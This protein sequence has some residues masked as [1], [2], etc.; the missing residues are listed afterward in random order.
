MISATCKL[1]WDLTT[2][3]L[4]V[5]K[6]DGEEFYK[7]FVEAFADEWF[8]AIG[9]TLQY[10]SVPEVVS[11]CVNKVAKDFAEIEEGEVWKDEVE[12]EDLA[13]NPERQSHALF[14]N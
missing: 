12:D 13:E 6:K 10:V 8:W 2:Q 5:P 1:T 11:K 3:T 14:Q 9:D 7:K 4:F